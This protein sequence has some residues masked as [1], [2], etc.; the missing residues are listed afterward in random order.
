MSAAL[1]PPAD[2]YAELCGLPETLTG[3]ILGGVLYTQP[4]PAGPQAYAASALGADLFGF[5][6]GAD[7]PGGWWILDEPELHFIRDA[8]VCVPD[9]AGWRRERM[10]SIPRGHR[11]EVAPDWVCEILSPGTA[12]KDRV[13]K[14]P[15]YA[16]HGVPHLWLVDPLERTLEAFALYEGKWMVIGLY[17]DTDVVQV[18]PFEALALPLANLWADGADVPAPLTEGR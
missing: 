18:A 1:E 5:G 16:R 14:M 17:Q 13:V 9:L 4:R 11:F 7:S 15:I 12:R 3:E 6:R 10:P 8:E 2:P